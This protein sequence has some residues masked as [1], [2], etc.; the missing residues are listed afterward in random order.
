MLDAA[1]AQAASDRPPP[2]ERT[3]PLPW[4]RPI[5]F[6]DDTGIVTM[7]CVMD[8]RVVAHPALRHPALERPVAFRGGV[9]LVPLPDRLREATHPL[10]LVTSLGDAIGMAKA[11]PLMDWLWRTGLLDPV[12]PAVS[13]APAASRAA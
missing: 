1:L 11:Q 5:R 6:A 2:R 9:A 4:Q 3:A 7:P 10:A 12:E 8:D 13:A